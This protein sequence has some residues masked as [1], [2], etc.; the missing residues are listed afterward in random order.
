M[1]DLRRRGVEP[2]VEGLVV[3]FGGLTGGVVV[4]AGL[5]GLLAPVGISVEEIAVELA[6][7]VVGLAGGFA[8]TAGIYLHYRDLDRSYLRIRR[9]DV[10]DLGWVLVGT[11]ALL[12]AALAIS[13]LVELLPVGGPSDHEIIEIGEQRPEIMLF[14][15]PLSLVFVGPGEELLFRGVVQTRLVEAYGESAGIGVTSLVFAVAHLP[16]YWGDGVAVS[17]LILFVL[18]LVIGWLFE[19]TDT[20]VVPTLVHGLYN[21]VLFLALYVYLGSSNPF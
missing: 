6:V 2:L 8:L 17:I 7:S 4:T 13:L 11:L 16:A 21:G 12:A 20:L 5:A 9:L 14:M 10:R 1:G 19:H 18:S 3:A 15:V